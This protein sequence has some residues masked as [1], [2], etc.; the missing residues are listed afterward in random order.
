M[1]TWHPYPS[2]QDGEYANDGA[3][4]LTARPNGAWAVWGMGRSITSVMAPT[5][6][7]PEE[8][9]LEAAKKKA[10]AAVMELTAKVRESGQDVVQLLH[11]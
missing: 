2:D 9:N 11:N 1:I 3:I 6:Y 4:I 5:L 7:K 8:Q 10:E